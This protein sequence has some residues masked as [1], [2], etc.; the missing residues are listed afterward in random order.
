VAPAAVG[1]SAERKVSTSTPYTS[2]RHRLG[3]ARSVRSTD[4]AVQLVRS[5]GEQRFFGSLEVKYEGGRVVLMRKTETM[6]PAQ[7]NHRN[8]RGDDGVEFG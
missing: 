5:L 3:V 8:S 6:K 1:A 2:A 4:E 7:W